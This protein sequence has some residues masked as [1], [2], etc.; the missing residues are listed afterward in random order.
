[1]PFFGGSHEIMLNYRFKI[2]IEKGR[3]SYK[4]TRFL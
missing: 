2:E 4:N 3:K 1:L